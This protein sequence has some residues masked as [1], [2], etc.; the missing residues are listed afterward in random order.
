MQLAG[1]YKLSV[2][3]VKKTVAQLRDQ[4]LVETVR[5][6]GTFVIHAPMAQPSV[7]NHTAPASQ[8]L[9]ESLI[10]LVVLKIALKRHRRVKLL[11]CIVI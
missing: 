2:L 3:T 10:L 9:R 5:E 4:G 8:R 11:L 1:T 6:K 7:F